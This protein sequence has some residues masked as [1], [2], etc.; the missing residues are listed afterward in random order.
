MANSS[1][2]NKAK[3]LIVK[4][5]INDP[6]IIAAIDSSTID[7]EEP[8]EYVGTHIY[9]FMQN[10]STLHDVETF[11]NVLINVPEPYSYFK[12]SSKILCTPQVDIWI[13]SHVRHMKVTNV[14][15]VTANR[16]DY[17]S[18]LI[19]EKLNGRTDFGIGKLAML[20]NEEGTLQ[21]D[22][23]YRRIVFEGMDVN[24]SFCK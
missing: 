19:D 14:P 6:N 4:E 24:D 1:F 9:D 2:I 17:L 18:I 21:T 5:F 23:V 10:P 8:E 11:I 22:Y 7:P 20:I 12:A 3:N 13:I 15:K 16:N